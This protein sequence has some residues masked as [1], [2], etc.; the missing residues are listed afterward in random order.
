MVLAPAS[1]AC[2]RTAAT[3]GVFAMLDSSRTTRSPER[4]AIARSAGLVLPSASRCC[5][6]RNDATLR[7]SKPTAASSSVA[8]CAVANPNARCC[9]PSH[10]SGSVHA[11]ATAPTTRVFPVPAGPTSDCTYA[12]DVIMPSTAVAWSGPSVNP[13]SANDAVKNPANSAS[14]AVAP[15]S[16]AASKMARSD[17]RWSLDANRSV[18]GRW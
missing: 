16:T 5:A 1:R 15:R 4:N 14:V 3:S 12:P 11:F 13:V 10:N 8:I 6:A 9:R 2:C 7:A 18:V 17:V